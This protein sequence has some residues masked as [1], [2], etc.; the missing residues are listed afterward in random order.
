M[1]KVKVWNSSPRGGPVK[2]ARFVCGC[3]W[4]DGCSGGTILYL[5]RNATYLF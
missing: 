3:G 5:L 1:S 2:G 4:G